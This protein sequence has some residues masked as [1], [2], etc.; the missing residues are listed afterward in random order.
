MDEKYSVGCRA[1]IKNRN[2]RNFKISSEVISPE[3]GNWDASRTDTSKVFQQGKGKPIAQFTEY[4]VFEK[5]DNVNVPEGIGSTFPEIK[6]FI[7]NDGSLTKLSRYDLKQ[8]PKIER[9]DFAKNKMESIDSGTFDFNEKL[10]SLN[11]QGNQINYVSGNV[12]LDKLKYFIRFN[13]LG[14]KCINE[15]ADC[16]QGTGAAVTVCRSFVKK[17]IEKCPTTDEYDLNVIREEQWEQGRR[18]TQLGELEASVNTFYKILQGIS[19][20]L[21]PKDTKAA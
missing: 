20:T 6:T 5:Q 4:V 8:F 16:M 18:I 13:M 2:G 10:Q 12:G 1:T 14:N 9:L 11:L 15:D 19:E 17:V 7:F 21:K 3:I